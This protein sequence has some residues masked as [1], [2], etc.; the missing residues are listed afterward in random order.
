MPPHAYTAYT[1]HAIAAST[2]GIGSRHCAQCIVCTQL[3]HNESMVGRCHLRSPY[4]RP[5][6]RP[7]GNALS[8]TRALANVHMRARGGPNQCKR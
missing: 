6:D 8:P 3:L 5:T 7:T 2:T 4:G 1:S